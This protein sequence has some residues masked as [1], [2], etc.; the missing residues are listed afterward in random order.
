MGAILDMTPAEVLAIRDRRR[1]DEETLF[2]HCE[3]IADANG[4]ARI[5]LLRNA[6]FQI[7]RLVGADRL[8]DATVRASLFQA[9]HTSGLVDDDGEAAVR[10]TIESGIR[11]G[12]VNPREG[13]D[14]PA[15]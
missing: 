1:A 12:T 8:D 4:G 15:A 2:D 6:A 5:T 9:A 11:A 10:A 13:I 3:A 7:G 14:A